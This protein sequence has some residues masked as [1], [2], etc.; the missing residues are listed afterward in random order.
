MDLKRMRYFCTVIEQGNISKAARLLNMAPPPLGKRIRELE[1]EIG[2]PLLLRSGKN[3]LPTEAGTFLYHHAQDIL[4]RV[5]DVKNKTARFN[6]NNRKIIKIG[7]SYLFSSRFSNTLRELQHS[8]PQYSLNITVSDSSHLETLLRDKNLDIALIQAPQSQ[9]DFQIRAFTP[10]MATALIATALQDSIKPDT[11]SDTSIDL[12]SLSHLPLLLLQRIKGHGTLE[13][14]LRL[15]HDT[16]QELNIVMKASDPRL[17]VSLLQQGTLACAILPA[18]EIPSPVPPH[19]QVLKINPPIAL[20]KPCAITL[21]DS[22]IDDE[23]L[24][25]LTSIA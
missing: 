1:Q 14:L 12:I 22:R 25:L 6:T 13:K 8:L 11:G 2:V 3:L 19:C 17:I 16:N 15:F 4:S 21:K 18:T 5:N 10:I 7:L 23:W 9:H 24:D 20:F